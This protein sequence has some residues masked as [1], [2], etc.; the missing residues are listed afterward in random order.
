MGALPEFQG[1]EVC[2]IAFILALVL[3]C[4]S[5]GHVKNIDGFTNPE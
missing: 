3:V 1:H 4:V 5:L 2:P